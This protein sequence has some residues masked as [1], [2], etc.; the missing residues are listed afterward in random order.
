[1]GDDVG[2]ALCV[3][4]EN[5]LVARVVVVV[6]VAVPVVLAGLVLGVVVVANST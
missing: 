6:V 4:H 2:V 3:V 1:M 5:V